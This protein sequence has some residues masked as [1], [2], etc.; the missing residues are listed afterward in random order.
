MVVARNHLQ[1]F[2]RDAPQDETPWQLGVPG[3]DQ[4]RGHP[5]SEGQPRA[6][7][8]A[9]MNEQPAP[10]RPAT[11]GRRNSASRGRL[12]PPGPGRPGALAGC[13]E[14]GALGPARA[15]PPPTPTGARTCAPRWSSGR[16]RARLRRAQQPGVRRHGPRCAGRGWRSGRGRR[17]RRPRRKGA[18]PSRRCP[19]TA[20]TRSEARS[21]GAGWCR[22]AGLRGS[23]DSSPR[24]GPRAPGSGC[25]T[26]AGSGP[27]DSMKSPRAGFAASAGCSRLWPVAMASEKSSSAH[28][29]CRPDDG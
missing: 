10:R 24:A 12:P 17:G 22:K 4:E 3:Q 2:S 25:R 27:A 9:G 11:P 29:G 14:L 18:A 20:P 16:T 23:R 28:S 13:R 26:T 5:E 1:P 19:E 21:R 6:A 7:T 8:P 15:P